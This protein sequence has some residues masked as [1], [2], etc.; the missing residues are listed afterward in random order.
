[1]TAEQKIQQLNEE[2]LKITI[3]NDF[4]ERKLKVS[5]DVL[6]DYVE[7]VFPYT[8]SCV[9]CEP[10]L[11]V[12]NIVDLDMNILSALQDAYGDGFD[13]MVLANGHLFGF[14]DYY[15]SLK[16]MER[17]RF[18]REISRSIRED[19]ANGVVEDPMN[20]YKNN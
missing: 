19:I 2:L 8:L 15:R 12:R 5:S 1:M 14:Q 10:Y 3:L 16:N 11:Y 17:N 20:A 6:F 4:K 18:V 9:Y 13:E 7:L